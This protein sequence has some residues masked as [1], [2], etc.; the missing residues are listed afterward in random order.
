[1][2]IRKIRIDGDPILRKKSKDVKEINE[3]IYEL[4][5]DMVE[6]MI[7]ANGVGLAAVQVGVLKRIIVVDPEPDNED[8][9]FQVL[10]NPEIIQS[11]GKEEGME[12][13]L[14]IPNRRGIVERPTTI[15]VKYMDLDGNEQI[16]EAHDF[17]AR[18]LCHEIDHT[19]G[20]LY[21]DKMIGGYVE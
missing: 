1:M 15:K 17:H 16:M 14:S 20:I 5:E 8:A 9:E 6:T 4:V 11:S 21:K 2:A 19:L 7:N 12:G 18:E 10:L 13:C 3:K